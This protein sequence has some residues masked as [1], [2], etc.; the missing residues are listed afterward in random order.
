MNSVTAILLLG[1]GLLFSAGARAQPFQLPTAN[2]ALFEKDGGARFFVGTVGRTWPSGTFGCVRSEGWQFHEG[3]DIRA[4][5]R[6]KQGEPI[7]PV[8]A[9]C[10]GTV[11]YVNRLAGE[12]NYG[13]YVVLRHVIDGMEIF[14]LYAHL[15]DVPASVKP[16]RAVKA[17]EVIAIM[18]R[19]ANTRQGISKERA[20][21][22]FEINLFV[23]DNFPLWFKKQYPKEKDDHR[24]WNG[25]N[26]VGLDPQRILLEQR[27][28]GAKFGLLEFIRGQTELCRVLV[29]DAQFS[30]PKRYPMLV[31]SNPLAQKEGIAGYEIAFNFNGLPF[32]LIPRAAGEFKTRQRYQLLSV[33]AAEQQ[34]NPCR[35]LVTRRGTRWELTNTGLHYLNLLTQ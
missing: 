16:G 34:K 22:H 19:T 15:S 35:R 5:Q 4:L 14:T 12:S 13:R 7:D 17:G 8:L 20:H 24:I 31:R 32:Q 3:L 11:A 27:A 25:M 28:K 1:G 23:S 29:R 30:W 18:G 33:N 21:V 2:R 6:N 9:S 26:L 10:D